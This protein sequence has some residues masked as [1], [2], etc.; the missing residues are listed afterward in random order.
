M[1]KIKKNYIKK[2]K[3]SP[4]SSG[5]IFQVVRINLTQSTTKTKRRKYNLNK[6][7]KQIKTVRDNHPIIIRQEPLKYTPEPYVPI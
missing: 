1:P 4:I 5:N 6:K 7:Q 3:K 2:I